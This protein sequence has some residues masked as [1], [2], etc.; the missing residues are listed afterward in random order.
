M[1]SIVKSEQAKFKL[2]RILRCG[3]NKHDQIMLKMPAFL[4]T[5]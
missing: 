3:L 4:F 5:L 2:V 1:A